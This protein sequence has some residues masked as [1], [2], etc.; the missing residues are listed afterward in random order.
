MFVI[1]NPLLIFLDD[2]R[3]EKYCII[4][5]NFQKKMSNF[6]KRYILRLEQVQDLK[7]VRR[8]YNMVT[9]L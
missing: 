7:N 3:G 8:L 5:K 2:G 1:I 4:K 6:L 9:H